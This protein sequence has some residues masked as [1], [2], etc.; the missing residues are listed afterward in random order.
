MLEF[1]A[2]VALDGRKKF[3]DQLGRRDNAKTLSRGRCR[4]VRRRSIG[5]FESFGIFVLLNAIFQRSVGFF[6]VYESPPPKRYQEI[7]VQNVP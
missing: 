3:G 1:R 4:T 5:T 6:E 2:P 7:L